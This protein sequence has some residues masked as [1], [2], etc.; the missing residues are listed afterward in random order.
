[1]INPRQHYPYLNRPDSPPKM[2]AELALMQHMQYDVQKKQ[3]AASML[4]GR[5]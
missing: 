3:D 5:G 1:M 2:S 4:I